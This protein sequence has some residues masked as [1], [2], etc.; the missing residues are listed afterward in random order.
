MDD[1]MPQVCLEMDPHPKLTPEPEG[2][3]HGVP[4]AHQ[5]EEEAPVQDA[6]QPTT[7]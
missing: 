5:N 3:Q 1:K 7:E 6:P 4:T 2:P